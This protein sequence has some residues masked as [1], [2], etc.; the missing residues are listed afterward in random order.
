M[1]QLLSRQLFPFLVGP[2][3]EIVSRGNERSALMLDRFPDP[4]GDLQI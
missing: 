2:A 1:E 4:E 3:V